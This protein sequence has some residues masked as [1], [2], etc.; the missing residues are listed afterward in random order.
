[1]YTC[2]NNT[3]ELCVCVCVYLHTTTAEEG[4]AEHKNTGTVYGQLRLSRALENK[5]NTEM[6][7]QF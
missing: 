5:N 6:A 2:M 3:M 7:F 1:M 4:Q